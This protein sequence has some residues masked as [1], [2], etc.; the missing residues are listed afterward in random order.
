[1]NEELMQLVEEI[2]A[3]HS[4][5]LEKLKEVDGPVD[6][7]PVDDVPVDDVPVEDDG[8]SESSGASVEIEINVGGESESE[9]AE[10]CPTCGMGLSGNKPYDEKAG[11]TELRWFTAPSST[12][13]KRTLA[14]SSLP[15]EVRELED[16]QVGLSG[17]AAV[18]NQPSLDLGFTERIAPGA[19]KRTL[20]MDGDV[21][22]L[23]EHDGVAIGRT[24]SGTLSVFEDERGL[25]I[26]ARVDPANPKVAEV[27]SAIRRGDLDG[28][29][30]G[31]R[32]IK[33]SWNETRTER[34]LEELQLFE[35]S[36]VSFPAYPQTAVAARSEQAA[37]VEADVTARRRMARARVA[38]LDL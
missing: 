14:T 25:R 31:F 9:P 17:Y 30:F 20:A 4:A 15:V 16:G 29:S 2:I 18:F 11:D 36:L 19:F 13:E 7:M 8:E 24:K 1:M 32:T 33:D 37:E 38:L 35:V 5:L 6:E 23:V 12:S 28:M 26:D 10:V 21:R 27:V 22:L 3:V 34:T